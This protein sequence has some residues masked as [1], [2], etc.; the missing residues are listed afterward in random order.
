[1]TRVLNKFTR[2]IIKQRLAEKA[3]SK[4]EEIKTDSRR[5]LAFLDMLI[6]NFSE[7]KMTL[8]DLQE[9]VDT[10]MYAGHDTN[11]IS[12]SWTLYLLGRHP[13]VQRKVQAE[14]DAIFG[15]DET[16]EVD[17]DHLGRMNYTEQVI[18]ESLRLFPPVPM[19]LRKLPEDVEMDGHLIP[20]GTTC[21]VMIFAMHR[22][23]E[24]WPRPDSFEPER[25]DKTNP[26][27][28]SRHPF[29]F[30]PFSAG[31]RNCIGQRFAMFE[32]KLLLAHLMRSFHVTTHVAESELS[33]SMGLI[34]RPIGLLY[35]IKPRRRQP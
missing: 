8:D 14:V 2:D 25:F 27:A 15:D 5:R 20:A 21:S 31:P 32:Q 24:V 1:M 11:A 6:S 29:A 9:E 12:L 35:S 28:S 10:F 18:K 16:I 13:D 19:V 22:N 17:A 4:E 34:T 23:P 30:V 26:D 7:E 3:T 33:V